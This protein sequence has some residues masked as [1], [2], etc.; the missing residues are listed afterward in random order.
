M[1]VVHDL[2]GDDF[3]TV[4][5]V[6]YRVSGRHRGCVQAITTDRVMRTKPAY[7]FVAFYVATTGTFRSRF[8][9]GTFSIRTETGE[10]SDAVQRLFARQDRMG[11][12]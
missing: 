3:G 9:R 4:V 11:R 5:G 7:R 1:R 8:L 6:R 12:T 2:T 10:C